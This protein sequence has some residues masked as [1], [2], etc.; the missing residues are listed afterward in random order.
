MVNKTK[1]VSGSVVNM[2]SNRIGQVA[3]K[4]S[5]SSRVDSRRWEGQTSVRNAVRVFNFM[6]NIERN[7]TVDI[8]RY[9]TLQAEIPTFN[10]ILGTNLSK[11]LRKVVA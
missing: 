3:D 9:Q 5:A 11:A 8:A 1:Q 4:L 10:T 7:Q 2:A 6:E